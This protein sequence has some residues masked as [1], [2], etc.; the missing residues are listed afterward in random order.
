MPVPVF[1]RSPSPYPHAQHR[2]R[3]GEGDAGD[4]A[5]L[6]ELAEELLTLELGSHRLPIDAGHGLF[7]DNEQSGHSRPD[8]D[9]K[10][11]RGELLDVELDHHLFGSLPAFA[12]A[13][14]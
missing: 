3:I 8:T 7:I 2:L 14:L 11:G 4:L 12:G 6:F 10:V 1:L 13:L 5:A 9:S